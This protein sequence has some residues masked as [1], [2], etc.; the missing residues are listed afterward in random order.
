MTNPEI[1]FGSA[2]TLADLYWRSLNADFYQKSIKTISKQKDGL[3]SLT[4][5]CRVWL[6][7]IGQPDNLRFAQDQL[8]S[9]TEANPNFLFSILFYRHC[10]LSYLER[11]SKSYSRV[12][13][14][15]YTLQSRL[16]NWLL[17]NSLSFERSRDILDQLSFYS[18]EGLSYNEVT[19]FSCTMDLLLGMDTEG[20]RF[21]ILNM[22]ESEVR[23]IYRDER[24]FH[25]LG[26]QSLLTPYSDLAL[27]FGALGPSCGKLLVDLGTAFGRPGLYAGLCHPELKFIGYDIVLERM[28][29]AQRVVQKLGLAQEKIQF[30]H[31]D[32]SDP[33]FLLPE[34]DYYFCYDPFSESTFRKI[35]SDLYTISRERQIKVIAT[36]EPCIEL[37]S[38]ESWFERSVYHLPTTIP[39]AI[40]ESRFERN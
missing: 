13:R 22:P 11:E 7:D 2:G 33:Q 8:S 26:S 15:F 1:Y 36:H 27:I 17:Q 14:A 28:C 9:D 30:F 32:L 39:A 25:F 38:R 6:K 10:I 34:A 40:F 16:D 19:E 24:I 29:E 31:Q 12:A 20:A 23:R 5:L 21:R 18:L 3:K 35:V 4:G 37:F